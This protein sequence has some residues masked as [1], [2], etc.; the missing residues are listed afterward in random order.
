MEIAEP[1]VSAVSASYAVASGQHRVTGSVMIHLEWL[2]G[3]PTIQNNL[4]KVCVQNFG[5]EIGLSQT[6]SI[7]GHEIQIILA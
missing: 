4:L 1:S 2:G 5:A 7:V 6:R 3:L